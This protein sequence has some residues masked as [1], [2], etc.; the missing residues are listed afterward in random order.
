MYNNNWNNMENDIEELEEEIKL[1]KKRI[2]ILEGK[3]NRRKA[4]GYFKIIIKIIII[5]LITYGLWQ[6]YNYV[7][8]EI[9][10]LIENK[11]SDINPFKKGN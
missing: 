10:K 7:V 3:E 4:F 5:G 1:L 2:S 8:N 11:V 6:G 9:P